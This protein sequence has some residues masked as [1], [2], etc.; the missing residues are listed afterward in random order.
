MV[1][2]HADQPIQMAIRSHNADR[3]SWTLIATAV[4]IAHALGLHRD[5]DGRAFTLFEA[6]LRRR[7]WWQILVLDMRASEDRGSEMMILD[8]S[9]NTIMPQNLND[10]DFSLESR[11]IPLPSSGITEITFCLICMDVSNTIL[12]ISFIPPFKERRVL[13]LVQKEALVRECTERIETIY[14]QGSDL[15]DPYAWVVRTIGELLILKLWLVVQYP[16]ECVYSTSQHFARGQSLRTATAF[17]NICELLEQTESAARFLWF[18]ETYVPWHPLAVALAELCKET[19]GPL[20]NQAWAIIDRG[21]G[22]WGERIADSRDGILWRP[23]K[24][25]MKKARAAREHGRTLAEAQSAPS[26]PSSEPTSST[27]HH[28]ISKPELSTEPSQSDALD[29]LL[30]G[31]SGSTSANTYSSLGLGTLNS[32]NDFQ[33]TEDQVNTSNWDHW[34]EFLFDVGAPYGDLP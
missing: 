7:L 30:F 15:S 11:T 21:Y 24:S 17:L 19:V 18:F 5:G 34:N 1:D 9:F 8:G 27:S 10:K 29:L 28:D 2:D 13:T 31:N 3:T 23:I 25:L 20:A 32:F 22:K 26:R 4:R 14:I 6:E 33:S 16:L 12:K